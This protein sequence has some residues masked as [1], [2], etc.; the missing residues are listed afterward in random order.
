M[1]TDYFGIYFTQEGFR[2]SE[3]INDDLMQPVRILFQN[4]HY[5][6]AIKLLMVAIDSAA[7]VEFGKSGKNP[8]VAWLGQYAQI[9]SL[10]ITAPELWEHRNFLLR[11]GHHGSRAVQVAP[12]RRLIGLVPSHKQSLVCDAE[13]GYYDVRSLILEIAQALHRW[14][15]TYHN[16]PHKATSFVA[17]YD[18][19]ASDVRT[20]YT[21][22]P[23]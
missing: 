4:N 3:L 5:V 9:A 12:V 23:E 1:T 2:F 6:S 18:C 11:I 15:A 19:M 20:M 8:F 21:D 7:Y 22:I 14:L 16:N 17:R 10:G 13:T